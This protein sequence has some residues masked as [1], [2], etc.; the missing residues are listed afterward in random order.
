MRS[1]RAA[2]SLKMTKLQ[3]HAGGVRKAAPG[4]IKAVAEV[5]AKLSIPGAA[6]RPVTHPARPLNCT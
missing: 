4:L 2:S 6:A 1:G 3:A 5:G